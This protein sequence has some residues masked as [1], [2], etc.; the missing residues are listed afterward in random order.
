MDRSNGEA[1]EECNPPFY[2]RTAY[3]DVERSEEVYSGV[4]EGEGYF[5]T[6]LGWKICH[7]LS[8]GRGEITMTGDTFLPYFSERMTGAY[9]PVFLA[10]HAECPFST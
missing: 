9:D 8:L 10:E 7:N 5:G 2:L 3:L 6:T 4:R 1:C